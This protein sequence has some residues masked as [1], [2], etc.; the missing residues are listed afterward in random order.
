MTCG[1]EILAAKKAHREQV[2][3]ERTDCPQCGWTLEKHPVTGVLHCPFC[4]WVDRH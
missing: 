1:E 3:Y 2:P 4:G